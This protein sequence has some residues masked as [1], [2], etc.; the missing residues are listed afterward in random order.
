MDA[1]HQL[2]DRHDY[3]GA[4]QVIEQLELR[5]ELDGSA[6]AL[7]FTLY[8]LEW[9]VDDAHF[10]FLR[11][12]QQT[13]ESN[14]EFKGLKSIQEAMASHPAPIN[15]LAG[16]AFPKRLKPYTEALQER[17]YFKSAELLRKSYSVLTLTHF[18]QSL[19]KTPEAALA[20]AAELGWNYNEASSSLTRLDAIDGAGEV[21]RG[22]SKLSLKQISS[23]IQKL[24]RK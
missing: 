18:A 7:L 11:L 20:V 14:P 3:P 15:A 24:E 1:A 4:I 21:S 5:G 17:L 9:R 12:N 8:L 2:L 22:V 13:L 6:K 10:L 16:L 23:T 19:G